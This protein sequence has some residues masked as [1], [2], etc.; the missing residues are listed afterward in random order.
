[1]A[2]CKTYVTCDWQVKDERLKW[3]R[4][5]DKSGP[6]EAP[7]G[8]GKLFG[9]TRCSRDVPETSPSLKKPSLKSG[10]IIAA[11]P[12]SGGFAQGQDGFIPDFRFKMNK[13]TDILSLVLQLQFNA[14]SPAES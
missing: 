7:L 13:P 9:H 10:Q 6:Q 2:T 5:Q 11:V 4:G 8:L 14:M 3:T 1:M 12:L